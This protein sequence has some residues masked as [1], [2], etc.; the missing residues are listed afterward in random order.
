MD[1]YRAYA[2][3]PKLEQEGK[4]FDFGG[5]LFLTLARS[6]NDTYARMLNKQYEAHKHTLDLKD[7]PEQIKA[8][9]D[10]S[11]KIMAKVM[12][13]SVLLG[14]RGPAEYNGEVLPYSQTNAEKF[15]LIKDFQA[16]VARRSDDFKNY[17]FEVEEADAKNSLS[18]SSGTSLG[19]TNELI[20]K[21]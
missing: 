14:W 4:E 9:K 20:S 5:G 8:G 6:G 7:T 21:D 15:L 12:A 10:L 19:D 16:E 2:T 17:R 18:T 13:G 11:H 3:D 1:L